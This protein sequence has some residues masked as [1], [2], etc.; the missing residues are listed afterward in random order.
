MLYQRP[1]SFTD[2]MAA[3]VAAG[4]KTETRR[5][6][7]LSDQKN[8]CFSDEQVYLSLAVRRY[9][10][11]GDSLWVRESH[12]LKGFWKRNG[13][14]IIGRHR[15][16]FHFSEGSV[17]YWDN[18][19]DEICRKRSE[20]GWFKRNARFMPYWCHR[21]SLLI[22]GIHCEKLHS[23]TE[24]GAK[25]EGFESREEFASYWDKM[26]EGTINAWE[27]NPFVLVLKF[28]KYNVRN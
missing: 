28:E 17:R 18:K 10:D 21:T 22:N 24:H 8:R 19:P 15:Y 5:T 27:K 12:Y 23:I 25:K 6:I 14:S 26:Y 2:L 9:G 7:R 13:K 4:L 11:A 20:K 3:R 16:K 1:I